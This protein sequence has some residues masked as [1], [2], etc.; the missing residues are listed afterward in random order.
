MMAYHAGI[1]R[2]A[3][4]AAEEEEHAQRSVVAWT[5]SLALEHAVLKPIERGHILPNAMSTTLKQYLCSLVSRRHA[6]LR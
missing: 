5:G 2:N 1:G 3:R 6:G 4:E